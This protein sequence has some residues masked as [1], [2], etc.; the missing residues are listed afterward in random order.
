MKRM[1][2]LIG[3]I[4][5]REK[6]DHNYVIAEY[7]PSNAESVKQ[8]LGVM[9]YEIES[10]ILKDEAEIDDLY[11]EVTSNHHKPS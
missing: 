9:E 10:L 3:K 1:K 6:P 7:K 4:F 11:Q 8:P 2:S 5:K